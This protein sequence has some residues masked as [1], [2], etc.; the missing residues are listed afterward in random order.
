MKNACSTIAVE[1]HDG[2]ARPGGGQLS[3][4][5]NWSP[6]PRRFP[7][8]RSRAVA[9]AGC[10]TTAPSKLKSLSTLPAFATLSQRSMIYAIRVHPEVPQSVFSMCHPAFLE[11]AR[12]T[13]RRKPT[14][15][16]NITPTSLPHRIRCAAAWKWVFPDHKKWWPSRGAD[17]SAAKTFSKPPIPASM[18]GGNRRAIGAP[19]PAATPIS[20]TTSPKDPMARGMRPAYLGNECALDSS[21]SV[22]VVPNDYFPSGLTRARNDESWY[23]LSHIWTYAFSRFRAN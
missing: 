20:V 2:Q 23:L 21:F 11:H 18:P 15:T 4:I 5:K 8:I 7:C 10:R 14:R 12:D 19:S 22:R 17:G 9:T 1:R 16:G 3:A 13:A 6:T